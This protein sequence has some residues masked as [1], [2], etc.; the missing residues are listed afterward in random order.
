MT[1]MT[2]AVEAFLTEIRSNSQFSEAAAADAKWETELNSI[3]EGV[4]HLRRDCRPNMIEISDGIQAV[5]SRKS[6]PLKSRL[7]ELGRLLTKARDFGRSV[8]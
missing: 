6:E 1:S 3:W 7:D 8:N 4:E 5:A 2:T